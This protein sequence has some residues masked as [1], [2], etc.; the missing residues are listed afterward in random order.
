MLKINNSSLVPP[1]GWRYTDPDTG[2]QASA[3]T[4]SNIHR[5]VNLHRKGNS[6][7]A[8]SDAEIDH[9]LCLRAHEG[10]CNDD[11]KAIPVALP[12]KGPDTVTLTGTDV[13]NGTKVIWSLVKS[14]R[15]LVKPE[16]AESRAR[17]CSKCPK[18]V[19]HEPGCA[20]CVQQLANIVEKVVKG[21]Q[22][23]MDAQL[24]T[25]GVCHCVNKV[26]IWVPYKH[27]AK[28]ITPAMADQWPDECWKNP[29]NN[30]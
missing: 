11:G 28:G 14:G 3:P 30:A 10:V 6:L 19:G 8:L 25:C 1:G 23:S 12:T 21:G 29:K 27:L 9:I 2:F 16:I 5:K 22:T 18:N 26:Q 7:P 17:I 15:R 4:Y 20:T 13:L 24:K